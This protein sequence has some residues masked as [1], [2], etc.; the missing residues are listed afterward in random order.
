MLPSLV[1]LIFLGETKRRRK[2]LRRRLS[3][4]LGLGGG[5]S[6][7]REMGGGSGGGG[8]RQLV[9]N[10]RDEMAKKHKSWKNNTQCSVANHFLFVF[11]FF[12]SNIY[13]MAHPCQQPPQNQQAGMDAPPGAA[14]AQEEDEQ[15]RGGE[16][17]ALLYL[18]VGNT[19]CIQSKSTHTCTECVCKLTEGRRLSPPF[20]FPSVCA[21]CTGRGWTPLVPPPLPSRRQQQLGARADTS[22]G[23]PTTPPRQTTRRGS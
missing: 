10:M 17:A 14:A 9:V 2:T 22:T 11:P 21:G 12:L 7:A 4:N 16:P 1:L 18:I 20:A 5:G 3:Y 8:E 19:R 23:T 13:K 15:A 6:M